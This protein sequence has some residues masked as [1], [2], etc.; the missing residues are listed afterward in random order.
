[1]AFSLPLWINQAVILTVSYV[2][3]CRF[4]RYRRVN[5]KHAQY[6]YKT[7]SLF[8]KM[9]N[10]HAYEIQRYLQDVEF[11]LIGETA[12]EFALFRSA[13]LDVLEVSRW[14]ER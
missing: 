12:L 11:P 4:L 7:R 10:Q 1:M 13:F 8:A 5:Q 2:L 14:T 6:P 3:L 9:T